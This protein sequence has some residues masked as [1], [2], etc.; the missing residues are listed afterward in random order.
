MHLRS[1]GRAL[2]APRS[3]SIETGYLKNSPGSVLYRL[4][5][6]WILATA[7]LEEDVPRW[8]K[9]SNE[10]W[11]TAEYAMLPASTKPRS[12]RVNTG[13]AQGRQFEIQRMIGRSLRCVV[14]LSHIPGKTIFLDCE[15]LQADGG[16]R[17]AS[18]NASFIALKLMV[19]YCLTTGLLQKNPVFGNV[20]SISVGIVQ[21][22][23]MLDLDYS[24]DSIAQ[25][26]MNL[27]MTSQKKIIEIQG[28]AEGGPFP[29]EKLN[30]IVE[31]GW[32]GIEKLIKV[33]LDVLGKKDLD[34]KL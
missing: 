18:V 22:K 11:L 1:G 6:T 3:V 23:I 14:D 19:D 2:D 32:S 26:D 16:T 28:N 8:L 12:Q 7:T 25:V 20:G 34:I 27:V 29:M 10:G 13:R 33:S 9:N 31:T 21:D 24:E 30:D 15:V 17:T 5:N 4:G